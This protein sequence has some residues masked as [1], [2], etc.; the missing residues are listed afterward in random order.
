M[1]NGNGSHTH[2][3]F[4][5]FILEVEERSLLR[6]GS[7]I[8][9]AS[10]PFSV[11]LY[12]I[13]NRD[14]V[15]TRVELLDHFWD[16]NDVYDDALRKCVGA[17][18]KALD[19]TERSPHFIETRRGSGYRFIGSV[20]PTPIDIHSENGS[21]NGFRSEIGETSVTGDKPTLRPR[22]LGFGLALVLVL[23]VSAFGL[24]AYQR[25]SMIGTPTPTR[26][27][28]DIRKSIAVLP[29][30]N[31][32]GSKANDYLSDGI[33]ESLINELS[34]V[35]DLKVISRSSAFQYRDKDV[36]AQEIGQKLGVETILEGAL[37]QSGDRIRVEA[38]LVSTEDGSVL[39]TNNAVQE[40]VSDIFAVQ[41]GITCQIV[42]QLKLKLC[43]EIAERQRHTP[44][45]DAY[46]LYLQALYHRNRL[47]ASD[48]RQAVDLFNKALAIDP[49]YAIAHQDLALTYAV[50]EV[51]SIVP[52]GSVAQ[53]A[54][55]HANKALQ[56][57]DSLSS[58]YIALGA[59]KTLNTYDFATREKYY[60]LA[61]KKEPN[62]RTAHL[63]LASNYLAQAKFAEAESEDFLARELDPLSSGVHLQLAE[64]Y[65]YWNK[66]D[67]I[68]E[69]A[70]IMFAAE[71][72][73]DQV[74]T[75]L[76]RAYVQ[77]GDFDKASAE[78]DKAP[79]AKWL[80]LVILAAAGRTKE[81][82]QFAL[83]TANGL[84]ADNDPYEAA[85]AYALIDDME[86][87]F[88]MLERSYEKHQASLVS[89]RI[90]PR[91]NTLRQDSR[92]P[93]FLRR[94]SP[95]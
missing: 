75:L 48:L 49:D 29:V 8:H 83:D 59:V 47:S 13:K 70:N 84:T 17:V 50:M 67:K 2:F 85:C 57:D 94:I 46:Q 20:S 6:E 63:W 88:A 76:A 82:R 89:V 64:L 55:Q 4:G 77:K 79:T 32:T 26:Q 56:L 14:R 69:E 21:Q 65:W 11:L 90:D 62:N 54:E 41:D 33:T 71:P 58:P 28:A 81:A 1:E 78:A 40:Q 31:L 45:A 39:W 10:R 25:G 73:N 27:P 44:N 95:Q 87:A 3:A 72:D 42:D 52:P 12:L 61:L 15:V 22:V 53:L 23:L 24:V 91:L 9:I 36:S 7:E 43:G 30:R 38:R 92:Y 86:H 19:D 60:R 35:E 51:N 68:I 5:D 18:R 34:R 66:P 74:P 16:G 37:K 93:E 80:R